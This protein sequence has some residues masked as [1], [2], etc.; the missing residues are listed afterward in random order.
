MKPDR[1]RDLSS[2]LVLMENNGSAG[3]YSRRKY[4]GHHSHPGFREGPGILRQC[5]GMPADNGE[6]E[7]VSGRGGRL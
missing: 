5:E 3:V 2:H 6:K 1:R 4:E 7:L